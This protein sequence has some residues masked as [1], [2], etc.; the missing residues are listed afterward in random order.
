MTNL[1][2]NIQLET[3]T[4]SSHLN[5]VE[6]VQRIYPPAYKHLWKNEDCSFYVDTF[7]NIANLK[8]ELSNKN[9]EYYFIIYKNKPVGICRIQFNEPLNNLKNGTYIH[10]M[11]LGVEAQGKGVAKTIFNWIETRAK[12]KNSTFLWLKAM[13]TQEQAIKFYTKNH[14]K[15]TGK[16]SLDFDL[17]HKPLR[18]M[19]IMSKE[20]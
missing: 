20:I 15:I 10:R 2:E 9:A 16:T 18:G 6:L 17:L 14:F 13:D 3:V 7:Y 12:E 4:I 1:N 8:L 5:L 19:L 11:Y